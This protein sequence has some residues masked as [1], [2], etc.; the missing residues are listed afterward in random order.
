MKFWWGRKLNKQLISVQCDKYYTGDKHTL[1]MKLSACLNQ[2]GRE[3]LYACLWDRGR[4]SASLPDGDVRKLL[5]ASFNVRQ[6]PTPCGQG[7]WPSDLSASIKKHVKYW[8]RPWRQTF[9]ALK[10]RIP[11]NLKSFHFQENFVKMQIPGKCLILSAGTFW[12]I[13]EPC[14]RSGGKE[15]KKVSRKG[16]VIVGEMPSTKNKPYWPLFFGPRLDKTSVS[17]FSEALVL[18]NPTGSKT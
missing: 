1:S 2:Q 13:S 15:L 12:G 6:L 7:F 3:C 17:Q 9:R 8:A 14:W 11:L 16:M 10:L 4:K 5:Q 18:F